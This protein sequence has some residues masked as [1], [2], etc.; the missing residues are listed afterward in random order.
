MAVAPQADRQGGAQGAPRALADLRVVDI[1]NGIAGAM[2]S[3]FLADFGATVVKIEPPGGDPTRANPGFATWNRGKRSLALDLDGPAGLTRAA[4]LLRGADVLLHAQQ[5]DSEL[6]QALLAQAG[7]PRLVVVRMPPWIDAAVP[8]G[9]GESNQ[10]LSAA[11]GISMRQSS[12]EDG[13]VDPVYAHLLYLQGIWGAA[14]ALSALVERESSGVGQGVT[15]SGPHGALVAGGA[16]FLVDTTATTPAPPPGPGGPNA[17]YTRYRCADGQW[18]F[19]GSLTPKFQLRAL[20]ALG[21]ED[22]LKDERLG[23]STANAMQPGT[24]EWLRAAITEAFASRPREQW[25]E[26]LEKAD[27]PAG[28]LGDRDDWLD[29]PQIKAIGMR[30]ELDDPDRGPVVMPGQP[31]VLT[32]S[33]AVI[34]APAPALDEAGQDELPWPARHRAESG[35]GGEGGASKAG[36]GTGPLA[37]V[38]VLDLGTILAGP[39]AGSLL[40][41]LGADVLKVEPPEGDSFRVTGFIYNKGMRSLAIDL[42]APDG[43][44]AFADLVRSADVVLD[45][46]RAGVLERLHIDY[47]SLT[48]INPDIITVSVTGYGEGGPLSAKPGFDPI[49]QGTSGMMAAQGGDDEPVFLT[50]AINDATAGAVCALGAALALYHRAVSGNGQRVW[51]S[52]AGMSA[53]VQSGELTRFAGRE[54]AIYGGR[55]FKGPAALDRTY[56]TSD[57]WIRLQTDRSALPALRELGLLASDAPTAA[58][59][60]VPT[61]LDNAPDGPLATE[62]AAGFATQ[63]RDDIALALSRR[64]IPAVASRAI[65][66]LTRDSALMAAELLAPH[67]LAGGSLYY[68]PGRYAQFDRT[69]QKAVLL[70]PGLGEHSR[71]ILREIGYAPDRIDRLVESGAVVAGDPLRLEAFVSYR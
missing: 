69:D 68:T 10:L 40:A 19:L 61:A 56:K 71:E 43:A 58:S 42:R 37:G 62:L 54:P 70:A 66:E 29:H 64:G 65:P 28:P 15:V 30:V 46:Y 44:Q 3:M 4:D 25:L 20:A 21:L 6:E 24:R 67:H 45:N 47:D 41:E 18:L 5:A 12:W 39:Y 14:C 35:S 7:N 36:P 57:G 32:G 55:D 8:W 13:P 26:A 11:M 48:A 63:R 51:T 31:L 9:G 52:L 16:T 50:L 2:A 59:G 33:P 1:T 22:L 17:F 34:D 38:R 27:C 49:L 60:N 53:L 23:G